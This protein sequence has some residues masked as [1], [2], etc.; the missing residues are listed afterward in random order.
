MIV[1][2]FLVAIIGLLLIILYN[3]HKESLTMGVIEDALTAE[4]AVVAQ[5]VTLIQS[6][7][8]GDV[9][10]LQA[11]VTALQTQ[12]AD[13]T[14]LDAADKASLQAALDELAAAAAHVAT[15]TATL[16]ALVPA[17]PVVPAP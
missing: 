17:A 5:I 9:A 6:L 15:Q 16:Q 7:G 4:D 11:Q 3:Q 2:P 13:L 8:T 12:V 1:V 14:A 10:T